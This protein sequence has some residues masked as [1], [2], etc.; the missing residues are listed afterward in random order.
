MDTFTASEVAYK[1]GFE[2]GYAEGLGDRAGELLGG[3]LRWHRKFPK[4]DIAHC[5]V[6]Y[7]DGD[8][9]TRVYIA[10]YYAP[11]KGF[12]VEGRWGSI[13]E[14]DPNFVMW[15]EYRTVTFKTPGAVV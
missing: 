13:D 6:A 11:L 12:T 1:N 9:V 7:R 5:F 15:G 3:A 4:N 2:R 8:G 14:G 10:K